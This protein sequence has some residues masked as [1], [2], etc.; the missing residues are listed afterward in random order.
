MNNFLLKQAMVLPLGALLVPMVWGLFAPG[1]SSLHQQQS[2]LQL[3]Q[4]PVA[5]AMRI[6]PVIT[7][8]SVLGFAIA[9]LRQSRPM[10]FTALTASIVAASMVANGLF[11]AGN[12]LH[13]LYGLT[14]FTVL[15]PACFSAELRGSWGG[16]RRQTPSLI[17]AI[18]TLLYMWLMVSGLHPPAFRGLSQRLALVVIFGWYTYA[19]ILL[20]RLDAD[21]AST[22]DAGPVR[23]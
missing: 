23:A 22:A 15:V 9:V 18:A 20:L 1:Y 21:N 10:P 17:V 5:L 7:G 16:D 14:I 2:E 4:H 6:F 3:L 12:P 13:G 11:V 19:S 8:V